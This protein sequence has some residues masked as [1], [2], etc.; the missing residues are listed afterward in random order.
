MATIL[1]QE[2]LQTMLADKRYC[3]AFNFYCN[4]PVKANGTCGQ[5]GR[6]GA[7]SID[8]NQLK[9]SV[10]GMPDDRKNL[11]KQ[12]LGISSLKVWY[13]DARGSQRNALI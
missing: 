1:S 6:N 2:L 8:W 5:C 3:D 13:R 9:K 11:M 4:P 10:L 12:M 7:Q